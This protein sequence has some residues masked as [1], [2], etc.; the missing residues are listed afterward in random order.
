VSPG[1][2]RIAVVGGGITGLAA[3][4]RLRELA[5]ERGLGVI[6]HVLER[7]DRAGGK[8]RTERVGEYLLEAGPDQFV[9]HKPG[10][11]ELCRRVGLADDLL[12]MPVGEAATYVVSRGR[13]VG[14]PPGFTML[15]PGRVLPL[16]RSP[17]LS[18]RGRLRSACEPWIPAPRVPL[19]DESLGSFVRR[20]FGREMLDR[21][22]EPILGGIFTADADSM[23]LEMTLPQLLRLE[24][25]HGSLFRAFRKMRDG[26]PPGGGKP[27][28]A[29]LS[30]RGGMQRLVEALVGRLP[31]D[32]IRRNAQ[33]DSVEHDRSGVWRVRIANAPDVDAD[34]VV[35]A[36]PSH[37][38]SRILAG[39]D[40]E[41]AAELARLEHAPCATVSLA[42]PRA[43]VR[44][45][46][47]GLGFFAGRAEG[48]PILACSYASVK[49]PDRAPGDRVV[50][51]AFL[52]GA[53][54]P[55]VLVCGDDDL[56]ARAHDSLARLLRI[57]GGPA[58]SRV[59]R[60]PA[61]MPQFPVGFRRNVEHLQR[62]AARRPGLV[63]GGDSLGCFGVPDCIASGEQAA[64][65]ALGVL[66]SRA[67]NLPAAS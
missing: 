54:E 58:M 29:C 39:P 59:H 12:E 16:L 45:P 43:A 18:W 57:E 9:Q 1:A 21:V 14:L 11:A 41:L 34:A 36:C 22:F 51:R 17:L 5:R 13:P 64:E 53:R 67:A 56:E 15:G 23:S 7:S 10:A 8:I 31:G 49:F 48:L 3:A 47:E 44:A 52:G 26:G 46:L 24:R 42:Y 27:R 38:A 32:C 25:A 33:V 28:A 37:A 63:L 6:L 55:D 19:A 65:R 62:L 2:L 4:H 50:L 20:R 61:S 35:L 60:F 66:A 40:P 30:L